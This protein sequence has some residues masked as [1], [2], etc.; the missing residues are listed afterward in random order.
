MFERWST[1]EGYSLKFKVQ[2]HPSSMMW[3]SLLQSKIYVTSLHEW[4]VNRLDEQT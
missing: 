3:S 1:G 4:S 2:I